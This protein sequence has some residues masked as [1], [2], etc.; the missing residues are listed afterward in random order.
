MYSL[1]SIA[2]TAS[3]TTRLNTLNFARMS[4]T[5]TTVCIGFLKARSD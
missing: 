1:R 4:S 2:K 3:S 5:L